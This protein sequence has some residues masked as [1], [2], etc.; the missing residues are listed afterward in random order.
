LVNL[1]KKKGYKAGLGVNYHYNDSTKLGFE[2]SVDPKDTS[3][4]QLRFGTTR[5]VD[6]HCTLK[7]RLSI[8]NLEDFRLGLVYKQVL[9][10]DSKLTLATDINGN[11]LL[12]LKSKKAKS[13]G[14][15]FGVT[16]SFFD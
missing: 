14:H 3:S 7:E 5:K 16:L 4:N 15:Q 13:L 6:D 10:H 9:S 12:N 2:A 1:I 8:Q 11:S